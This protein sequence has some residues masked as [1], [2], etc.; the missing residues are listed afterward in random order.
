MKVTNICKED[1]QNL[2]ERIFCIKIDSNNDTVK[3]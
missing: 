2:P 1:I 3:I